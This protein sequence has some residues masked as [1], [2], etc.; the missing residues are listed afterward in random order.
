MTISI[1]IFWDIGIYCNHND[2]LWKYFLW[3]VTNVASHYCDD[4][5]GKKWSSTGLRGTLFPEPKWSLRNPKV[6]KTEG[7]AV[8]SPSHKALDSQDWSHQDKIKNCSQVHKSYPVIWSLCSH[9]SHIHCHI[10]APSLSQPHRYPSPIHR[11]GCVAQVYTYRLY[12]TQ[13]DGGARSLISELPKGVNLE[14]L[15]PETPTMPLL[16]PG[17]GKMWWMKTGRFLGDF[18]TYRH[19]KLYRHLIYVHNC[20]YRCRSVYN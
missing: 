15:P 6:S 13:W 20:T 8:K 1:G 7:W 5:N 18:S 2:L 11:N 16:A 12:L 3:D 9:C 17:H 14:D 19:Y 10:P 4:F